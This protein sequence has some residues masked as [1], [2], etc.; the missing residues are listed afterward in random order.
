MSTKLKIALISGV[1]LFVCGIYTWGIPA[2]LNNDANRVFVQDKIEQTSGYK[3]NIGNAKLSMGVFPSIWIKSDNISLLNDDGTKALSVDNPKL[4]LKLLPLIKKRIEISRLS[5]DKEDIYLVYSKNSEFMI[6]QYPIKLPEK[7]SDFSLAKINLNLGNYNIYLNDKKNNKTLS[8]IGE[9]LNHGKYIQN[10]R[11]E[12]GTKGVFHAGG[13]ST[14]IYAD[15]TIYLPIDKISEDKF[16]IDSEIK[17]FD[18][19][20]LSDYA[21]TLTQGTIRSLNGILNISAN[22]AADNFGHK[23][24]TFKLKTENLEIIGQELAKSVIFKEPLH[25]DLNLE[26]VDNGILINDF[27]LKSRRIDATANGKLYNL[28]HKTPTYDITTEVKNTRT[29][30]IV[31]LLPG[32]STLTPDF[33]LYKLKK[34]P[35]YADADLKLR[36]KGKGI[37]PFVYG[38]VKLR[39]AYLIK[40]LRGAPANAKIDLDFKDQDMFIDVFVPAT[41]IN[42]NVDV[43]G[44]V[45]IDGTKYSE[46]DIKS[47]NAVD[48]AA[49]QEVLNPLHEILKFQLGP[50]PMMK[51][52]GVGNIDMHSAGSKIDPHLWGKINFSKANV[53][54]IDLHNLEVNNG[55][56]EVVFNDTQVTFK[57]H[58]AILNGKPIEIKGDCSV[59][60]KL[61]VYVTSKGQDIKKLIHC[62]QTSPILAEVQRV[63]KPFTRPNGIAD[64]FLHIYG[65]AKDAE[66]V[67]F[68][69]DLFAKGTITLHNSTTMLQDTFLPFTAVNGEVNFD[70]YNCDYNIKG[71]LRNSKLHVWGTGTNSTIDLKATSDKIELNNVFDTL[72]PNMTLP[73]KNELGKINASFNAS[74]KG[75]VENNKINYNK[76]KVD[77]KILSNMHT[78]NPIKINEGTF[79]INNG[80]LKT[81]NLIGTFNNTPYALSF[82]AKDLDK[83]IMNIAQAKFDFRNFNLKSINSM[84][85][86]LNLPDELKSQIKNIADIEGKLNITGTIRNNLINAD[87]NL[88]GISFKYL[89]LDAIIK[90]ADGKIN[91]R[92]NVMYLDKINSR[93]SSMPVFLDGKI[94]NINTKNPEIKLYISSKLTQMF[95]DRFFNSKS[96]YPVKTKGDI[97][98]LSQ[99]SGNLKAINAKSTLKLAQNA[100]IYYMGATLAGAPTGEVSPEGQSTNPI[101]LISDLII[102]PNKIKINSFNYNQTITSQN[103]KKSEQN[104]VKASGE[105]SILPDKILGLKNLK[106]KTENPTNARIF[107]AVFKKPI[108]KQG[109]FLSDLTINGTS[110]TPKILGFLK[111]KSVDIP[112]MNSTIQDVDIDFQPDYITLNTTGLV[113]TSDFS[114]V[115]KILNR[116][117]KPIEVETANVQMEELNLNTLADTLS[118]YE[119]DATRISKIKSG[120]ITELLPENTIIIKDAKLH[121]DNILIKKAK[122]TN[123]NSHITLDNER[124]L[125]IDKFHFDIA[126]GSVNGNISYNLKNLNGLINVAINNTDARIIADQFFEMPDQIYGTVTG[127]LSASCTGLSGIDCIN[128][129]NGSGNFKVTDGRMPKL[130]SLEY[131]LKAGNLI[132]GGVTGVSIN[133]IIDLITPL[134]TGEFSSI[135]GDVSVK[136]GIADNINVYSSGKDLSMYMTGSYNLATLVADMEIYGSL[137]KN[138]STILGKIAN[139]SL[140]TLFNTIPGIR[141]N[142]INPTSTSNILKIPNFDKHNV[143]RVFKAEIY[144]DING[145]NYVKSFRWIKD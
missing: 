75:S 102:T 10:K 100:S 105:I 134:K 36:F 56:G 85:E 86:Q 144:G 71:N 43:R 5:A 131:L 21:Q 99:I 59:L 80:Y 49:A 51:A 123:F 90:V 35:F 38:S 119:A 39:N 3:V 34:Y 23:N 9:Y 15:I 82:S 87:T 117:T 42:Q 140:N 60:G 97:N 14:D 112:L 63:V 1:A 66:K 113:M 58:S 78:Q 103:K 128:T 114:L 106:I 61:N 110:E 18:L 16:R 118:E 83:E 104:Q 17:D 20:S 126:K 46:L 101:T 26:T 6:G 28:G 45:R 44:K 120:E 108:I 133:G 142:D 122:A 55:S 139:A 145:N 77:G 22:T 92:N 57:T 47:T 32:S 64:V 31:A 70:K 137:S 76:L 98:F 2:I 68:N 107:N 62:I 127:N 52:S 73:F 93:L 4:K 72:H 81:S 130:G 50:V 143:L 95:F 29:E 8:F 135:K 96:V 121:A 11:L 30:D 116:P 124:N 91:I 25:A 84:T 54:L 48:L 115:A 109:V 40:P 33:D 69:Q 74:Y 12:L 19:S 37:R 89:P 141:I 125:N 111:V 88:D 53:S 41:G 27:K 13:K 94:S 138:F 129:L 79:N 7:T 67:V 24:T 132:T 136:N 65:T